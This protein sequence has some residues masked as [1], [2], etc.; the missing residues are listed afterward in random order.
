MKPGVRHITIALGY[1][2]TRDVSPELVESI[3][4]ME[5]NKNAHEQRIINR[6]LQKQNGKCT[7]EQER[8]ARQEQERDRQRQQLARYDRIKQEMLQKNIVAIDEWEELVGEAGEVHSHIQALSKSQSSLTDRD[9]D[10]IN[11]I[12]QRVRRC[13]KYI[14]LMQQS[15]E[16][17][18]AEKEAERLK[19]EA[20]RA[21][22]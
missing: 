5:R 8:A 3:A 18:A 14:A 4:Q 16:K 10:R 19:V 15:I 13:F 21:D 22:S 12:V 1:E 7:V 11:G 2:V 6:Q 17:E 9:Y 20:K